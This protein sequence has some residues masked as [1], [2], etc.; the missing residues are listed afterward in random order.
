MEQLCVDLFEVGAVKFGSFKLK[1]GVQSPV[2]FDLRVVV[3][4]PALL[5]RVSRVLWSA[6]EKEQDKFQSICG[7]PYT[8]LPIATVISIEQSMPMLLRRKEA[9][10]YGTKKAIEGE[11]VANSNC[12][13]VEDVVTSGGSVLETCF[14]LRKAGVCV[15]HAVVLLDREQGG[16][17]NVE[18]EG[19][20]L[21]SVFT[22]TQLVDHLQ[23]AG[24]I[25]K[26]TVAMVKEFISETNAVTVPFARGTAR[27][28]CGARATLTSNA[29]TKKL[30]ELIDRKC[31]NLALSA[32]VSTSS[33]LLDLADS[34]GPHICLLKTHIDILQDYK[35]EVGEK[36]KEIAQRHS[37][38]IMED[39]KFAD[40]GNTV[41]LQY[42]RHLSS[43]WA[44]LVTCHALPGPGVIRGL[45]GAARP[46][47]GC[48]IVA[49]MSTD[50][51]LATDSY[52]K[53]AVSMA[54]A[55]P[56]FVVGVVCR[57]GVSSCPSVIHMTPG[58]ALTE[59][60]DGLGQ[61]YTT[62]EAAVGQNNTDIVIV[63]RAILNAPDRLAAALEFK[64]RAFSALQ[65]QLHDPL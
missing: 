8:A 37:F 54:E 50:G 55:H 24:K 21:T 57:K 46:G 34:L 32:D 7:V 60:S 62:P 33:E 30:L 10:D 1:S 19:V 31:S 61:K 5:A 53:A 16:R 22:M 9:K 43:G 26:D 59:S 18:S 13:V 47:C 56:D 25:S 29:L 51:N 42:Q 35:P 41:K 6:V 14:A 11:L 65:S 36:L 27:L 15:S 38:M 39:R 40:I 23:M 4:H 2:Y 58:I 64:T 48:V 44:E 12:L 20:A 52:C 17:A 28:S 63:G 45:Q 49:E 3:S